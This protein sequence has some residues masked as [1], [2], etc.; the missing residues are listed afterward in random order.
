MNSRY[1]YYGY[2]LRIS[3][4]IE[5]PLPKADRDANFDADITFGKMPANIECERKIS[6]YSISQDTFILNFKNAKIFAGFGRE[7]IIESPENEKFDK[8]D[9][10]PF[11]LSSCIGALLHQRNTLTLHASSVMTENGAVIFIGTSSC[12]K[13]T[14]AAVFKGKGYT[15]LSDDICP[16]EIPGGAN[17]KAVML[18]SGENLQIWKDIIDALKIP[19]ESLKKVRPA[20][21]K[22]YYGQVA[23]RPAEPVNISTIYLLNPSNQGLYE[24][25]NKFSGNQKLNILKNQICCKNFAKEMCIEN[26]YYQRLKQLAKTVPLKELIKPN[27]EFNAEK[28]TDILEKDFS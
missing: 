5:L 26:T 14:L 27:N 11:I 16:L 18:P 28:L 24:I 7:I 20:I 3:S 8:D 22:Y 10:V 19:G 15:V 13:S 2:G 9:T 23:H 25:N 4:D 21:E 1:S 6:S 12:G 17:G